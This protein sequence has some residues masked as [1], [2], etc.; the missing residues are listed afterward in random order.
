MLK[1]GVHIPLLGEL[2]DPAAAAE[3]AALA[4]A[5]GWDG[6]FTW[7]H[8]AP[9]WHSHSGDATVTLAAVAL[10]TSRIR[11]G[12]MVTPLPRRRPAKLARETVALDVLSQGRLVLGVGLGGFRKEFGDLGDEA[13]RKAR[14]R[15]LD[16]GLE[17][18]ERLWC[19][20]RFT[21]VGG[22]YT[23][24][25]QQFLPRPVQRPRIPI[26]VAAHA[27]IEAPMLR[28]ARWD[29]IFPTLGTVTHA[30]AIAELDRIRS[31][32]ASHRVSMAGF[33][34]VRGG[35]TEAGHRDAELLARYEAV[36]VTWW[37]EN[38]NPARWGG[39]DPWPSAAIRER[40]AAGPPQIDP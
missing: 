25:D 7:D 17:L 34:I 3:L 15:M 6:F 2:S 26:W 36:G 12:P 29:G 24:R 20:E 4:E 40:I 10:R 37:L 19:G 27:G 38:I 30:A 21:H 16:E 39:W 31:F 14:G 23:A 13:D 1:F 8:V 22:R 32:V 9:P 11:L 18:L 28:A 5:S 33:D 35:E